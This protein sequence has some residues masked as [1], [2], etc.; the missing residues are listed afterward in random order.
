MSLVL[1]LKVADRRTR[2]WS[3]FIGCCVT[4]VDIF[5]GKLTIVWGL[6][7][8]RNRTPLF[9]VNVTRTEQQYRDGIFTPVYVVYR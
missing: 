5:M 9:V 2:V 8:D 1:Y 6:I 7:C 3:M 4:E